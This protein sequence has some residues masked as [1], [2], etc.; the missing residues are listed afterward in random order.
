MSAPVQDAVLSIS[1]IGKT[2]AQPVLGDIDLTLMRG[3]VLALTGENGAGKSTLSKIIGGL[4]VPDAGVM[5][6]QGQPYQPANRTQAEK[7]GVRMVMQELNLLP[8]LTVAEN[9]FLDDM[10]RCLG[11]I[12]RKVLRENAIKAM[13][14]VGLEA[15]DPDTLVGDLGIGHQQMVEIARN[16]AGDC[17]VLILDEPTAMLTSREVEMLF[18]QVSRLQARGVSIIYISHRLEELARVAQRIAVLRDGKLVCVEPIARYDS[19]Q[20]VTLMVGRELGEHIDMGA[21]QIGEVALSVKGLGRAG[22][23]QDVSFQV[24]RGEIFGISGLIGAGRTELLR[25]IYGAD[26]ADTGSIE[27]GQPLREVT[28]RSP[29][30]AVE[31]GIAL[32]TEDRKGEGLLMSQSISANVALGNMP[33][34]SRGGVVSARDE[35]ALAQRQVAAMR[36]RS[37]SPAQLVSEL[38]GGNQQ[39][40][41]IGRWLERDCPVMLFDEPTRG[42]DV[43]AKFDIYAL[44]GELT[45]QGRALVV[46]SSDLRELMLI[47]DRIGV[48]SAGRLIDT[49]ERD[50]WT[51]DQLL[52]AAFAGYQKRDALLSEAAPRND[53]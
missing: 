25:L 42:I 1:G 41:V 39:K 6:F 35:L 31:H 5:S 11:W 7:L 2:Y 21:R 14:Q 16:L 49:F 15:I 34:I 8:T 40:V 53:S 38:S 20:L 33:A 13:A 47:C 12:D 9:L 10:P 27:V 32:I 30:D 46:V 3:E 43:G 4:V 52:A 17:H 29:A 23:V 45:R 28:I 19:E 24:R 37:S 36:I 18:E 26:K 51:Q 50:N 48:L 22:K 44:L